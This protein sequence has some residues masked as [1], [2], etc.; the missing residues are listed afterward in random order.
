MTLHVSRVALNCLACIEERK[1]VLLELQTREG[2]VAVQNSFFLWADLTED[3]FSV[4]FGSISKLLAYKKK[5]KWSS[6]S[7]W[8]IWK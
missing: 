6:F 7:Q 2:A 1:L 4:L 5:Q 3:S 8:L